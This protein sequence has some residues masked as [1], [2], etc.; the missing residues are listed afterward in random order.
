MCAHQAMPLPPYGLN[1]SL[2]PCTTCMK[3]QMPA[4]TSAGMLKNSGMMTMMN[5]T[6]TQA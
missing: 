1:R 3:N 5:S 6:R 2:A 4:N